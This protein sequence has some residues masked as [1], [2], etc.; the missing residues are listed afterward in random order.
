MSQRFKEV[1]GVQDTT[2]DHSTVRS[3]GLR[4]DN[5][6]DR[7][8]ARRFTSLIKAAK[9]AFDEHEAI[10]VIR[11]VST[12]G[13]K[14]RLFHPLP[15]RE[16][17]DLILPSGAC[18]KIEH[19]RSEL[20]NHS[21][22]FEG[23]VDL[24]GLVADGTRFAKRQLRV[25]LS[26]PAHVTAYPERHKSVVHNISQQGA[27]LHT[28]AMFAVQQPVTLEIQGFPNIRAK[29]RWRRDQ[30]YGLAFDN[31]FSLQDFALRAA[32]LQGF[33]KQS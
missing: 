4:N 10:C 27:L 18:Y 8:E 23:E 17:F 3:N 15:D 9:I 24:E 19:V 5:E 31:T 33:A 6:D 2:I 20:D 1:L 12:T 28:Q 14:L 13:I 16:H 11:D 21:F 22:T 7:R 32:A 26:V 29:V 25:Q 30:F